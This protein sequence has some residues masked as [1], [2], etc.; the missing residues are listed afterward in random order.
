MVAAAVQTEPVF[1]VG[2]T[3][4]LFSAQPYQ[5]NAV[6]RRYDVNP[7]GER[8]IFIRAVDAGLQRELILVQNFLEELKRL[9]AN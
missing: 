2:A 6:H 5:A 9:T 3:S 1:S 8:F 4:V 7:D